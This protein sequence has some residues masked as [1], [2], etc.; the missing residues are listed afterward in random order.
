MRCY[1]KNPK[2]SSGFTLIEVVVTMSIFTIM[3]TVMYANY[4]KL[5]RVIALQSAASE[6]AVIIRNAQ[7]FGSSRG[8]T[9]VGDGVYFD[10]SF[11]GGETVVKEFLDN[12]LSSNTLNDFGVADS[13]LKY[14][15]GPPNPD[16]DVKLNKIP[17]NI[18]IS[19]MYY[20]DGTGGKTLTNALSIVYVRPN[21]EAHIFVVGD[22]VAKTAAYIELHSEDLG[23]TG[24][25]CVTVL[26]IG[27]INTSIGKCNP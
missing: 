13:D 8:G 26:R 15:P 7:V 22:N 3:T 6:V 21:S 1:I 12:S 5:N 4:P 16:T 18:I 20:L 17:G 11:T 23:T 10:T 27:Q 2:L 19:G 24:Y 14:T 25:R 9:A